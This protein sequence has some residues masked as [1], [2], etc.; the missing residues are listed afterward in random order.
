MLNMDVKTIY[1]KVVCIFCLFCSVSAL[2][3]PSMIDG[4]FLVL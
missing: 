2:I 3:T 4:F 1:D